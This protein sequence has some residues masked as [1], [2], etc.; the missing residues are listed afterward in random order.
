MSSMNAMASSCS[1]HP[2]MS[3][4]PVCCKT[5]KLCPTLGGLGLCPCNGQGFRLISIELECCP[6]AAYFVCNPTGVL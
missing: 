3:T 2:E 5:D 1:Q 4:R 6:L